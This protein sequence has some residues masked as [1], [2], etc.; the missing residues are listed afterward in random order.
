MWRKPHLSSREGKHELE[1]TV[2]LQPGDGANPGGHQ[3]VNN[4]N[5]NHIIN[6]VITADVFVV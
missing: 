3:P 1:A 6:A 4:L 2:H 5:N